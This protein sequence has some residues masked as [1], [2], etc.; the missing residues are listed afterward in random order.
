MTI[1]HPAPHPAVA[2]LAPRIAARAEEIEA[3]RRLPADLAADLLN[4]LAR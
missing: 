3:A 4:E 1:P 2:D